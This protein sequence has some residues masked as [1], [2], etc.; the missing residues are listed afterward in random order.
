MGVGESLS[1]RR[2]QRLRWPL[3]GHPHGSGVTRALRSH[4]MTSVHTHMTDDEPHLYYVHF[5]ATGTARDL[6][7]GLRAA[8]DQ[9]NSA[10]S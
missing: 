5:F 1:S 8:L 10:K 9:T 4:A 7:G 2:H 6:A 3:R